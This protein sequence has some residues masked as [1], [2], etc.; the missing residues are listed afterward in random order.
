M[1]EVYADDA[2]VRDAADPDNPA[3]GR[4]AIIARARMILGGFSDER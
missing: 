1:R 3:S 4:E 2:T